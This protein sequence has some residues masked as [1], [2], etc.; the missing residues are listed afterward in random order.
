MSTLLAPRGARHGSG[1]W[2]AVRYAL[3]SN[4]RTFRYCLMV[5]VFPV[6]VAVIAEL[7]RH[8]RL[9][10]L[11]TAI[12]CDNPDNATR[13]ASFGQLAGH[14]RSYGL[15]RRCVKSAIDAG[16]ITASQEGNCLCLYPPRAE[17]EAAEKAPEEAS[18]DAGK[19]KSKER[20]PQEILERYLKRNKRWSPTGKSR[21]ARTVSGGLPTLGKRHK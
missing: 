20:T 2:S 17:G 10:G 9:C 3:D 19:R 1:R 16:L 5:T 6:A 15:A 13:P 7:M 4:A 8:T 21:S 14:G 11:F 12:A 18:S